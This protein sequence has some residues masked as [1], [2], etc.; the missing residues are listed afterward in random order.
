MIIYLHH[1]IFLLFLS[2]ELT[3]TS[4]AEAKTFVSSADNLNVKALEQLVN[5]LYRLAMILDLGNS[6]VEFHTS[7]FALMKL[8]FPGILLLSPREDITAVTR[9]LLASFFQPICRHERWAR[10]ICYVAISLGLTKI[11]A[12]IK[13]S[14]N[15]LSISSVMPIPR[16]CSV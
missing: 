13:M 6:I 4:R 8:Y 12:R 1:T 5:R 7:L 11:K 15:S 9:H 2:S 10:H 3:F 16:V 14:S